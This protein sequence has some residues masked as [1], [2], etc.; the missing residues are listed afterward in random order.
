M[1]YLH[2]FVC[3]ISLSF[4]CIAANSLSRTIP[5]NLSVLPSCYIS[6]QNSSNVIKEH[7]TYLES[8]HNKLANQKDSDNN[9]TS[10]SYVSMKKCIACV[11]SL[12]DTSTFSHENLKDIINT[13][14]NYYS[15]TTVEE[16]L[17]DDVVGNAINSLEKYRESNGNNK[18]FL[19]S[20]Q[21]HC[22]CLAL[23][24]GIVEKEAIETFVKEKISNI[25]TQINSELNFKFAENISRT[26]AGACADAI[27]YFCLDK[28][29]MDLTHAVYGNNLKVKKF[30]KR[31]NGKEATAMDLLLS[32][33][34]LRQKVIEKKYKKADVGTSE[35]AEGQNELI[36]CACSAILQSLPYSPYAH[37]DGL[38]QFPKKNIFG[39]SDDTIEDILKYV[40]GEN[41]GVTKKDFSKETA[42]S[43][44]PFDTKLFNDLKNDIVLYLCKNAN[45]KTTGARRLNAIGQF[46][47]NDVA[48]IK[49]TKYKTLSFV[50]FSNDFNKVDLFEKFGDEISY[51]TSQGYTQSTETASIWLKNGEIFKDANKT[52]GHPDNYLFIL[53]KGK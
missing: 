51:Q 32:N 47:A 38:I 23:R 43:P 27:Q 35:V 33:D 48:M 46:K 44:T 1:K 17:T 28:L 6:G 2:I 19:G 22:L 41:I 20:F 5:T 15:S 42:P 12:F 52:T 18:D 10:H 9:E 31:G 3:F 37:N 34:V 24:R 30:D 25:Q 49:G 40:L 7:I 13:N 16:R 21:T 53:Y 11:V 36:N 4:E 45:S 50:G 39:N 29:I 14:E 8:L 26:V